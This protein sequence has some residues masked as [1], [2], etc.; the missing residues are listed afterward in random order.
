MRRLDKIKIKQSI[1]WNNAHPTEIVRKKRILTSTIMKEI[2]HSK[3]NINLTA[4]AESG[5]FNLGL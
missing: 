3:L 2:N 4:G 1:L 5:K